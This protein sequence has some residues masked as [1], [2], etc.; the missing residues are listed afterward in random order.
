MLNQ[1]KEY[2]RRRFVKFS[3]AE[4]S[5]LIDSAVKNKQAAL[6]EALQDVLTMKREK[7]RE[8]RRRFGS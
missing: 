4:L 1:T 3:R 5:A 8:A 7:N 6:A 2:Y